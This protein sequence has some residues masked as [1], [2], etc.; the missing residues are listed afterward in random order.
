[1][2]QFIDILCVGCNLKE[3]DMD[4]DIKDKLDKGSEIFLWFYIE[5]MGGCLWRMNHD[6]ADGRI[7]STP[8]IEKDL[9][10]TREFI[11][12]AVGQ[13]KRFGI[14]DPKGEGKDKY[15]EW[16]K[17]W[18]EYTEALSDVDF[19]RVD[20]IMA[21]D[22]S[23]PCSDF[24]PY[25]KE[26]SSDEMFFGKKLRELRLKYKRGL[27]LFAKDLKMRPSKLSN[28][29]HGYISPWGDPL[30]LSKI[31][32]A[33]GPKIIDEDCSEL[34]KLFYAHFVMQKMPEFGQLVHAT[35]RVGEDDYDTR[36]ATGEECVELSEWFNSMVEEHNTKAD[37]YNKEHGVI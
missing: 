13:L 1:M 30:F 14:E 34:R 28:I 35:K 18:K 37:A 12:Y 7:E 8:G 6:L 3:D 24:S 19:K 27:R 33:C 29:E 10:D 5:H 11:E 26:A 22:I 32:A 9:V 4:N 17:M 16:Y 31:S 25:P 2:F 15:W 20:T 21:K 23:D 36:P